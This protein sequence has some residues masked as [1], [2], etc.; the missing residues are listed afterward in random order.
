MISIEAVKQMLGDV[1]LVE[2]E[3]HISGA[4]EVA[5]IGTGRF[6]GYRATATAVGGAGDPL[7]M[8][9]VSE[10]RNAA[11]LDLAGQLV[12]AGLIESDEPMEFDFGEALRRIKAGK[13]CARKGWNG[14]GMWIA[15]SPG[16][17]QL[18]ADRFWSGANRDYAAS[19]GG[20]AD[21]LPCVTMKTA[22]GQ[23][24]MGWLASQADMLAE[25]WHEVE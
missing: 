18:P 22:G 5:A 11:L 14:K 24:V 3:N 23:I 16:S 1:M 12:K 7:S 2:K 4:V 17:S 10:A 8:R 25:D 13:R 6:S 15:Y 21:V 19:N 9:D 20:S